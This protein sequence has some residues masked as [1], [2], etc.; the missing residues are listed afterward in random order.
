M[1]VVFPFLHDFSL[2]SAHFYN[3]S[4]YLQLIYEHLLLE[5]HKQV[6]KLFVCVRYFSMVL[7][8]LNILGI[9]VTMPP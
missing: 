3:L 6:Q 2:S 9:S 8:Y 1:A 5:T 4:L 7:Q